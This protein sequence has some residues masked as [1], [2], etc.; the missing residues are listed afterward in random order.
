MLPPMNLKVKELTRTILRLD[1]EGSLESLYGNYSACLRHLVR[2]LSQK[3]DSDRK[4][5]LAVLRNMAFNKHQVVDQPIDE[6]TIGTEMK[7]TFRKL[8]FQ[9]LGTT[10]E[11]D[12]DRLY[13]AIEKGEI[14]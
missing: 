1:S 14:K 8:L 3:D 4:A 5:L 6:P 10:T 12:I 11:E 2:Y 9:Q 7:N 13:Q